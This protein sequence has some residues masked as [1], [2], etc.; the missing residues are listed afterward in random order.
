VTGFS[1]NPYASLSEIRVE[2]EILITVLLLVIWNAANYLVSTISDG[3]GRVRDVI[4]GTAY[5]LFPYALFSL[6]IALLSNVL[7]LNEVFIF[8]F[9][10]DIIWFWTG[11]MLFLMVKE[12]HNYSFGETVKNVLVTIFTMAL[13]VLTG[14]ILYVLFNQ[15][16]DFISAILQEIRLRG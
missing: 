4:I 1:F 13:F 16:Y 9:S 7:S 11:L 15:L 10:L 12:I 14:Y 8:S 3:E 6:P 2:N 5:S